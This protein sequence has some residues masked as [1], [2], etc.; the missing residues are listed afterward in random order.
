MKPLGDNETRLFLQAAIEGLTP[1]Q[2]LARDQMLAADTAAAINEIE[3]RFV[4]G[5]AT[6]A[7]SI[8]AQV[9]ANRDRCGGGT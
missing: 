2:I 6:L 1:Q 8:G 7:E 3:A 4:V 9:Q 5:H